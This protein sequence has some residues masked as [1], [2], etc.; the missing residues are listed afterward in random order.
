MERDRPYATIEMGDLPVE[1]ATFDIAVVVLL[2]V[3]SVVGIATRRTRFPY[4][5][6]LVITGLLLGELTRQPLPFVQD[7]R[8]DQIQ[9]TPHLILVVF[10][11]ALLF[12]ATL[13]I[14]A[15]RLRRWLL[16]IGLLAVP[17]VVIT[18]G[19]VGALMPWSVRLDWPTALLFGAIVAATDPIAV[20]AIFKRLS[21]SRDLELL[22]EGESL[23]NDGTAVVLS[24]ILIAAVA[25]GHVDIGGGIYNFVLVVGGGVV[26]GTLTGLLASRIT[27]TIDDH[28][29]EI[30][31]TTI[32]AYGTFVTAEVLHV[33]GVIAVVA[34]GLVMGNVGTQRGMSPT[35]RL[36]LLN[37]WEY[38]A[39]LLNSAIFLVIGL[40]WIIHEATGSEQPPEGLPWMTAGQPEPH[41]IGQLQDPPTNLQHPEAQR[42]QLH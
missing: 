15:R 41:L 16:P 17:G 30:T 27:A 31:L 12:E 29:I 21:A 28:L 42:V 38:V 40:A 10:L 3:I 36:A 32:L 2:L 7:L 18:A 9:L 5:I 1:L 24:R 37:F 39:F 22:V 26:V 11:P 14:E 20:L 8:L 25:A 33:S 35:T 34:A 4:P 23:F 6:A 19:I 13:H